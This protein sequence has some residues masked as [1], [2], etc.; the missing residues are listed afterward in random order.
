M[1]LNDMQKVDFDKEYTYVTHE[2]LVM[3][4]HLYMKGFELYV[5]GHTNVGT[6]VKNTAMCG[7]SSTEPRMEFRRSM[8][9][10]TM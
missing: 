7:L 6:L 9:L 2:Q 4:E 1:N 5:E 10:V 3:A 8:V